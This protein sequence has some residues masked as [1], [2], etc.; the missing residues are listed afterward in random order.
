MY[1][2]YASLS[3]REIA[4]FRA[5]QTAVILVFACLWRMQRGRDQCE[6]SSK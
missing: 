5:V 6:D 3:Q 4:I 1:D 2:A